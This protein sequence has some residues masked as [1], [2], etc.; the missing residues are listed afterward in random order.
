MT[1]RNSSSRF[2]ALLAVAG[3]S[4]AGVALTAHYLGAQTADAA[5]KSLDREFENVVQPLFKKNCMTCHSSE[6]GT[7]GI[8]VDQLDAT[9][10]DRQIATWEAIRNRLKAG[11]MPPKG[12]PQPTQSERDAVV[13]WIGQALEMA[14]VRPAPNNGAVRRLTVA[15]YRNTLKDLLLIDDDVTAGLPADA[16]SKEGFLNNKDSMQLSPLLTQAYFEIAA[17]ALN[18]AIVDPSKKPV[19][20]D[21]RVDLARGVNPSPLAEEIVLGAGSAL[22]DNADVLV[23]QPVPVKPFA[24]EPFVMRTRFRFIEGYRG[25]DT[26]RGWRDFDSIYH[27]VFADMR[28]TKGYPKGK[29]FSVV[30]QGLLLRPAIPSEETF[31]VAATEGPQA[32]FKISVRELPDHGRFRVTVTAAKYRDGLMLDPEVKPMPAAD[33]ALVIKDP[34]TPGVLTIAKAGIYQIDLQTDKPNITADKSKL[35]EGLTGLWPSAS[36]GDQAVKV[37]DSPVGKAISLGGDSGGLV[38]P[39]K[40]IPT[41]DAH[42]VGEGDFTVAL[43]MHPGKVQRE[44]IISLGNAERTQ[45]WFLD[46]ADRGVVR[47]QL[48][49]NRPCGDCRSPGNATVSTPAGA[50][51]D[52]EWQHVAVVMRRGRNDA[53]IYVNGSLITKAAAG[54]AQFDD[55]N[56]DLLIGHTPLTSGFNGQLADV[57][58]YRRP[59]DDSE[60][61]ALV[62]PGKQFVKAAPAQPRQFAKAAPDRRPD[63]T[64]TF[65]DREFA[66]S[67]QPAFVAVR[68][69]AGELPYSVKYNGPLDLER[70]TL[71]PVSAES[72]LGKKFVAFEKRS[73]R[74]GVQLGLRRDCG[75]TFAPVGPPR[76]VANEKFTKYVFEGAIDNFPTPVPDKDIVNY[77]AGL[78]EIAVRSEYT[79]ARDMPRLAIRSV[80]FEGPYYDT[81]PTESYKN[82]F[83][84]FD[85]KN[86]RQAYGR[87]IIHEFATRA[88]RR[89]VT[90]L[91]EAALT[92]V[93]DKSIG[94]GRSFTDSVKDALTVAMTSP[95]FLFLI[96]NSKSAAS[97]PLDSWELASKLSYFLWNEPPDHKLLQMAAAGTLRS[98]LDT[99]VDRMV[100]DARFTQ[101]ATEFT[102]QWLSLDKF[103]VLESD[104]KRYPKLT[105]D[106]RAQLKYEPI[107]FVQ[108]LI[109]NNLPAKNLISSPFI[110]ANETV[111]TYYDLGAK[112]ESGFQFVP[113]KTE[114]DD[115]GGLLTQAAIMAG[116]SDGRESNPVKRGAWLARKIIAEPPNDPPPNVPALKEAT[117]EM[118]LK[119]RLEQHHSIPACA[120]C[121]LKIDPWGVALEQ[122]DAGGRFKTK[123]ADA[124]STLP[125]GTNVSGIDGLRKY[126]SEDRMDQVAFSVLKHLETYAVGR[127]LTYNELSFLKQDELR[128]KAGGYRMRDM[129]RYVVNSKVFLEK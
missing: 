11:T 78:H 77:L 92:G 108:Y 58:I 25:N 113:I 46:V 97:E 111:A 17:D 110:V 8:R 30:P 19:I 50:I 36:Q 22:L 121:H 112:T 116:L 103:Q 87:K 80:E 83:V 33:G 94:D 28:G 125:D 57:R 31:G 75:S 79:D 27:N 49:T 51:H 119:E 20:Q 64:L 122:Y 45:G 59:L 90:A 9:L 10:Q 37:E 7:A 76:T 101:F 93:F 34:M 61:L 18:R 23:T 100:A 68:L 98:Q 3:I 84:D 102:S 109:R 21:F 73:P 106:T 32:N 118:T 38:V 44:G 13:A 86:D 95:Q 66:G 96:E 1:S 127:S 29:A 62:E 117:K 2:S 70:I 71:T 39:R 52:N 35:S 15:Q 105:R 6:V 123:P 120:Q 24:F 124:S 55:L 128:L 129:V 89:P 48:A 72:D 63:V 54:Y 12:L 104:M 14:R 56:A 126:L 114:R 42:N 69:D 107:E 5:G 82:I 88:Y 47:F 53:R 26:V 91:E 74:L 65:G 40:S 67:L 16:V 4:L 81:W 60:I 85:R 43:W 115:L 41:D 99:E